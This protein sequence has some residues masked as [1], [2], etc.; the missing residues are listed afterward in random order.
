MAIH[1]EIEFENDI[2]DYLAGNG[3]LY[4][5]KDAADYDR[6]LA[7]FPADVIAW[8]QQTDPTAWETLTKNHGA[9]V[10]A[11]LLK[12]LRDCLDQS[13]TL[14]VIRN[15]FDVLGLRK[16]LRMAQFKPALAMNP[17][18]MQRY[19]AN[20][21]RVVRQVK[22][23]TYNENSIDLVLFLNGIP[24]AT[25]ELKTDNTQSIEDAVYQYKKD[26]HP[27]P[28]GQN[29]EP[30]LTFPSGALVH[31]AVSSSLVRM[32]TH[33]K[34]GGTHFLPFDLGDGGASGNPLNPD[35][36]RTSYLWEQVW[37]TDSW[38]EILGRYMVAEK[39]E[40]KQI[41][42]LI[43]PRYHQLDATR[44][45]QA[46]VLAEG[47]GQKYLIQHSAGSGKTNSIAWS[48]H[49]LADLHDAENK[50]IFDTVLV[51][52]DRKVIDGQLQDAIDAFERTAGVVSTITG[53][54]GSK[55]AELAEALSGDKKIV[56]CTIQTFPFAMR[57]VRE[58]AATEDKRFAV[59]ADEAHSSQSGEAAS[60][61]KQI[62]SAEEQKELDDG[63]PVSS[64]DL[65]A[66]QMASRAADAGI[67]YVAFTATPKAKTLELFG[68]LPDPTQPPSEENLPQPFHV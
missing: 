45:L 20:R 29:P 66:A 18:I 55:S 40:K 63:A 39:D 68:R 17:D 3:W 64:E 57:A 34:G 67:T 2:C 62:L 50:K 30:L 5:E 12:R 31:F 38:L 9:A 42:K 43:F 11:I 54:K 53:D 14:H 46:A 4:A 58:L 27:H 24:V 19:D 35:G 49:F 32:T 21:L 36:Y 23:S 10:E 60:K 56:V 65:L 41:V 25:V 37:Q 51:V 28:K 48:A 6:Q 59:I 61:L 15:G 44:R 8:V 52:S 22:Y 16:P 33:L 47:A 7:L 13:G 1:N 26:R